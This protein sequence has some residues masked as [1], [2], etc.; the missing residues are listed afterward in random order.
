[1]SVSSSGAQGD[2]GADLPGYSGCAVSA[3]GRFV[4]FTSESTNFFAGDLQAWDVFVRDR[5]LGTTELVGLSSAGIP[6][7][8]TSGLMGLTI[9]RDG[10]YVAFQT[11]SDNLV[12]GDTNGRS[13]IFVRDRLNATTV[14]VSV[15]TS[16]T[17]GNGNSIYPSISD[18][19]RYVAF[20]SDAGNLV[21]GDTNL[22]HDVFVH[23]SMNGSTERVSVAT[24]G[25]EGDLYSANA[26]IS[27]D[28]R[29]VVFES[30]SSNLVPGDS[31]G[32][33]DV[34]VR[35]RQSG[36]TERVSVATG[37][38]QGNHVSGTPRLSA[39]GR[40]VAFASQATNFVSGDTNGTADVFLHDRRTGTTELVS[41]ATN[42]VHGNGQSAYPSIS[43]DG[44]YVA[45]ESSSSNLVSNAPI[46]LNVYVRD[47]T[48]GTTE[49]INVRTGGA[50]TL[51]GFSELPSISND[52]RY[53]VFR[54][55]SRDLVSGDTNGYDDVFLHDRAADGFSSMCSPAI[56]GVAACPCANPPSGSDRGCN[57]S[58]ATG[59]AILSA[60]GIAYLSIDSLTFSTTGELPS[61][62]SMLLQGNT[63]LSAG[64]AY[65]QGVRCLT[66]MLKRLYTRTAFGGSITVPDF[67]IGEP[68]VSARS[69][70]KGDVIQAGQSRWYLVYYRD[71][72]VLGGCPAMSTFNATQTGQVTWWP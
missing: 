60:T 16:G 4:V 62:T 52:G 58:S 68:S 64:M 70:S 45:F 39:D 69:A 25:G 12:Q 30:P 50:H 56:D 19:G 28:G 41:L 22:T 57:N 8:G 42:G 51:H 14:R 26:C 1:M 71:P 6:E 59:G 13:D 48:H 54:S 24:G 47:R 72:I 34:F 15:A 32:D 63:L 7:D 37:G 18:D 46:G 61:A 66:G 9:S 23:D 20:M 31:N 29:Y 36:T 44:C 40:Y 27:A 49:L 43:A 17:Q 5:V 67:G 11:G 65:G 10:R 53:V 21:P 35:D 2:R 55:R 38:V 33:D 3:D